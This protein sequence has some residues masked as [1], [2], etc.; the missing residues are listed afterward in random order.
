MNQS[1]KTIIK[2]ALIVVA[3]TFSISALATWFSP[4]GAPTADNVATPFNTS[5]NTQLKSGGGIF[6]FGRFLGLLV[7]DTNLQVGGSAKIG[8]GGAR[9]SAND[10]AVLELESTS[11]G[12]LLPRMTMAQRF[13]ISSP[14]AGL[15]VYQTDGIS[16]LYIYTGSGWS[17]Y[18]KSADT[19]DT[20]GR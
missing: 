5:I 7:V 12:F 13:A 8:T 20:G 18:T 10:S 6:G 14:V 2:S 4:T 11:K 15:M 1:K 3:F 17:V 19:M 16:G 9:P